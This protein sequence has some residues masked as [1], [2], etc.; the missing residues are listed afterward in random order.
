MARVKNRLSILVEEDEPLP[1]AQAAGGALQ[2]G[3]IALGT[4]LPQTLALAGI[5]YTP[6]ILLGIPINPL[7]CL[8]SAIGGI[9]L[10]FLFSPGR[11][12]IYAVRPGSIYARL[13]VLNG[14][15]IT[16]INGHAVDT[17]DRAL[18]AYT[19]LRGAAKVELGGLRRGKPFTLT[20][21]ITP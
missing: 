9:L 1:T 15:T 10:L 17:A 3:V 18:D 7:W 12:A 16:T 13:G 21:T 19:A 20:I 11:G 14:D 5:A 2:G 8:W 4:I 6:L